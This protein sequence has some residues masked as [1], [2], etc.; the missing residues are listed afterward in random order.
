[1]T[2]SKIFWIL[3]VT[4]L[5]LAG[6]AESQQ[7]PAPKAAGAPVSPLALMANGRAAAG[8]DQILATGVRGPHL[9]TNHALII[10]VSEY[11]RS[12]LPGVVDDRRMAVEIAQGFGVPPSNIVQLA[13]QDVTYEGVHQALIALDAQ[14]KPGDRLFVYY[15]GHGARYFSHATNQC[16]EG[17]VAQNIRVIPKHELLEWLKPLTRK[18]DKT[19]VMLDS[20]YS[21]GLAESAASRALGD[22]HLRPKFS[23]SASSAMCAAQVNLGQISETRGLDVATTDQNLVVIAAARKDE[24]AWDADE[25]GALTYNFR[26]CLADPAA[27]TDHSGS[28]SMRELTTCVQG[29]L[30]KTQAADIRQHPTLGGNGA[31]VPGFAGVGSG[32]TDALATLRDIY[33]ERDDRWQ[34]QLASATSTVSIGSALRFDLTSQKDGYL[35]L[36]YRGTNAGSLYLLFPNA[37]DRD[38]HVTAGQPVSLPRP[39]WAITALGPAGNDTL[40]ALVTQTPRDFSAL[41]LPAEYVSRD[42]PFQKLQSTPQSAAAI[43]NLA[44]ISAAARKGDCTQAGP[45]QAQTCSNVFGAAL[46]TIEE[47]P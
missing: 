26:H 8:N 29:R 36:F 20:C 24:A 7:A 15:S 28:L 32:T 44:T 30:D 10:T 22:K 12:P 4:T 1:M 45:G 23:S 42:G 27:D 19:I 33:G 17:I 43:A 47:R 39:T 13:E 16:E 38:N 31:L 40:L 9:P 41:S 3:P 6:A 35:Y 11:P 2:F 34:V 5:L 14:M 25:G 46:L 18:S 37:L 21:G